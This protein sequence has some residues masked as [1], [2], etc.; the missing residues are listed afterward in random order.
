MR[1]DGT[2][3]LGRNLAGPAI[4]AEAGGSR[5]R[6]GRQTMSISITSRKSITAGAVGFALSLATIAVHAQ[7]APLAAPCN[8]FDTVG[9]GALGVSPGPV[10]PPLSLGF[11]VGSGQCN[12]SFTAARPAKFPSSHGVGIELAM[13]AEQRSIGQVPNN[14]GNYLVETGADLTSNPEKPRA[15]WNFQHS[16]AYGGDISD[17]DSLCF[18]IRTDAGSSVPGPSTDMLALRP[19]IDDRNNQPNSTLTYDDLY[20]TSQNPVFG[21]FPGGYDMNEEGA[22]TLTLTALRKNKTAEV[23][24]CIHTPNAVCGP[25]P[26]SKP[27]DV[28]ARALACK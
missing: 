19:V 17:L 25:P 26:S 23:S 11:D 5:N 1:P 9:G 15:W 4:H 24:I 12:G 10:G 18:V 13:R 28:K 14:S 22:W 16:I 7:N 21:W 8:Q 3:W 27:K 6:I 20:Q 2:L